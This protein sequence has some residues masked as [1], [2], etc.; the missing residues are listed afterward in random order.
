MDPQH[1]KWLYEKHKIASFPYKGGRT[2]REFV[3][4]SNL[5][6]NLKQ[7]RKHSRDHLN[8]HQHLI[9]IFKKCQFSVGVASQA[10]W[11]W[12]QPVWEITHDCLP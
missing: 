12:C 2:R 5:Q 6:N 8:T 9:H 10:E 1:I 7:D 4:R 11:V 3:V